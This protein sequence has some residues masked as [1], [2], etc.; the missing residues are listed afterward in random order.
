[1][2]GWS[3]RYSE[4]STAIIRHMLFTLFL[5]LHENEK[6]YLAVRHVQNTGFAVGKWDKE[7][8][9]MMMMMMTAISTYW[10]FIYSKCLKTRRAP[11]G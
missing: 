6:N 11:L 7:N 2:V 1:M 9:W 8:E 3:V 4:Y 10:P 5:V